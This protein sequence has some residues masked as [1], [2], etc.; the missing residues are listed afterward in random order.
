MWEVLEVPTR[1]AYRTIYKKDKGYNSYTCSCA[2]G[3]YVD[4]RS[5]IDFEYEKAAKDNL[6]IVVLYNDTTVYRSMCPESVRYKGTHIAAK[7][8]YT[9]MWDY[10]AIK[11]A[12]V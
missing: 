8:P 3:H 2:R 11:R 4:Y 12:I 7:N 5:F 6:K 10:D 1:M 9:Y